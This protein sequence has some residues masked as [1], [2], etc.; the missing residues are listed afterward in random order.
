MDICNGAATTILVNSMELFELGKCL[1]TQAAKKKLDVGDYP[2]ECLLIRHR[3]GEWDELEP[4][5]IVANN[6]AL[7][8][9]DRIFSA[10]TIDGIK[11][12]VITEADR[13][14]TTI[15]LSFEN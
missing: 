12:F 3:Q 4:E 13:S 9:G 10:Y 8:F 1:I 15:M 5:D 14:S 7:V 2:A 6:R 11:F